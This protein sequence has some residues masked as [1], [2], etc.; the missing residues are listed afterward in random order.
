MN[1]ERRQKI[2][3]YLRMSKVLTLHYNSIIHSPYIELYEVQQ[4]EL[5]TKLNSETFSQKVLST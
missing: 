4:K 3:S 2:E 1:T 5:Y